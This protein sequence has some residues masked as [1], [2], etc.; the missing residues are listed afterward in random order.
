VKFSMPPYP[1]WLEGPDQV[2]GW[3]LGQGIGCKGSK[4][5]VTA[6]NGGAAVGTYRIASEGGY[7]P[8]ALQV[9]ETEDGRIS[10]LHNFLYPEL[11]PFFGLPER[12]DA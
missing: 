6:A 12:L 2:A 4:V 5:L 11:F 9:I 1:M 7:L 8:F 10:G 3:L